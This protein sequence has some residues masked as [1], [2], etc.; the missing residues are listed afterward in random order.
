[1]ARVARDIAAV[2]HGCGQQN[3]DC[4]THIHSQSANTAN[5]SPAP[6]AKG[7]SMLTLARGMDLAVSA[8]TNI[9]GM[10]DRQQP[11]WTLTCGLF[12]CN[13]AGSRVGSQQPLWILTCGLFSCNQAG[14]RVGSVAS[15]ES[16]ANSPSGCSFL[17]AHSDSAS[18]VP[19]TGL[20]DGIIRRQ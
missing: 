20:N 10:V 5:H 15:V 3:V 13:Q 9:L 12:S 1:M 8:P 7:A 18:I 11:L 19:S 14:S 17:V 6:R 2:Q 4:F 16:S